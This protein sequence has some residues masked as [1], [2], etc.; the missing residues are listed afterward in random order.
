MKTK[1]K[2][3]FS[4]EISI[5]NVFVPTLVLAAYCGIF[6]LLID[7]H[8]LI[9]VNQ[10]FVFKL[11]ESLLIVLLCE[12]LIIIPIHILE[13]KKKGKE[14][15]FKQNTCPITFTDLIFILFPLTPIVQYIINNDILS[16]Y[17]GFLVLAFFV[18]FS[19]L[20]IL[21]IPRLLISVGNPQV[22]LALGTAFVSTIV[23]MPIL[24]QEFNWFMRGDFN[25]QV[26]IFLGIF[27]LI[28][29][30]SRKRFKKLLYL[31]ILINFLV[32]NAAQLWPQKADAKMG[33]QISSF[34]N[35]NLFSAVDG[36]TPKFDKDV[37]LLIYESYPPNET[38]LAY[39]FD[40]QIQEDFLRSNGFK[41]Y[42]NI[43]SIG[44]P[45]I[46][47]LSR[48]FNDSPDFYGDQRRGV[49]GDGVVQNLFKNLGYRTNGIVT[50]TWIF[51]GYGSKYDFSY[52]EIKE[53]NMDSDD[54][55]ISA[56]LMGEFR[57]DLIFV[58]SSEADF[59]QE[60]RAI[61]ENKI[62]DKGFYYFHSGY[63]GHS[64]D[65]GKCRSNEVDIYFHNLEIANI[66]MQE[67]INL[68]VENHPDAIIIIAGDHGPYLT[69]SCS[70]TSKD[71][72]I[73]E[74]S[75]L[76]IQDRFATFLAIRWP[77]DDYEKFDDITVLQD[78]FPTVFAYLFDDTSILE[79][80]INPE[81]SDT[82]RISGAT[83]KDG[84]IYGG[85]DDGE[86]LFLINE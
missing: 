2:K 80:K 3:F 66:E 27:F 8:Q 73:S 38:L 35:N 5:P 62:Q 14:L 34:E 1:L 15:S 40:N 9:G 6:G 56:T 70:G 82:Q 37:F 61:L 46:G 53:N 18:L 76:D 21:A 85:I 12:A 11:L 22:L 59:V 4:T 32:S 67:D 36:R 52:P 68:L 25:I 7:R 75:R 23:I 71:Y 20:L 64:Q 45:T 44:S 84:I 58:A 65:S 79:S 78:I 26:L 29:I 69:K 72:D 30:L 51:R 49:A 39:G 33:E 57:S 77:T 63:P 24:S 41:Y 55:L 81:I 60:K 10:K 16:F 86:P 13:K 31:F 83:V 54:L 17:E 42:P 47:S 50:S 19:G 28:L 43:Y 74:I 48:L